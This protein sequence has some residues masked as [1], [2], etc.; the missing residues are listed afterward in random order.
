MRIIFAIGFLEGEGK[1]NP[2]LNKMEKDGTLTKL[3]EIFQNNKYG[4]KD[5][6]AYAAYSI[7]RLFKATPIPFKFGNA[8]II[9]LKDN[10]QNAGDAITTL[11]LLAECQ[12]IFKFGDEKTKIDIKNEKYINRIKQFT[13]YKDFDIR[14][15]ATDILKFIEL[16]DM[17][18]EEKQRYKINEERMKQIKKEGEGKSSEERMKIIENG[19]LKEICKVIHSSLEG[20]MNWNKQF[21]IQLGCEA[22][23]ILL[24]DNKESFSFAIESGGIIDEIISLLNKLPIENIIAFNLLPINKI[25]YFSSE[26]QRKILVD[27]GILKV[28]KK[29]LE[30]EMEMVILNSISIIQQLIYAVG[31]YEEEGKPNPLLKEMEKDGTLNKFIQIFQNKTIQ[32]KRIFNY[33]TFAIGYLFKAYPLPSEFGQP[34]FTNLQDLTQTGNLILQSDSI[35]ALSLLAECE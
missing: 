22:A 23:S 16:D 28:I 30:S 21:L 27:K 24:E 34:I 3:I 8:I 15:N 32:D 9:F 1:P 12:N 31:Y 29:A 7:G 25:V 10:T 20:E 14:N 19:G 17:N 6:N 33:T 35:L 26:Q 18:E 4:N 13:F 2:V 11:S 5:V